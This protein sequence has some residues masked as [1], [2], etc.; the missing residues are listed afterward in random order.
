MSLGRGS[1]FR[2]FAVLGIV[3]LGA[4]LIMTSQWTHNAALIRANQ[5][6]EAHV[7]AMHG[8]DGGF[9]AVADGA[10]RKVRRYLVGVWVSDG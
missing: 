4:F 2:L 10:D 6:T 8:G 5:N 1:T 9:Q 3:G 7:V